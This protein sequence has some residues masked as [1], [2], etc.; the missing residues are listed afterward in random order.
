MPRINPEFAERGA[1]AEADFKRWLDYSGVPYVY[2]TQDIES[3][4]EGFRGKLKRP[5]YLVG[6]PFVGNMAFDVKSKR[7]YEDC[8]MFDVAEVEKLSAFDDLFRISTFFACL[9]PD[10]GDRAPGLSARRLVAQSAPVRRSG[11]NNAWIAAGAGPR[12]PGPVGSL[13]VRVLPEGRPRHGREGRRLGPG[14][15]ALPDLHHGPLPGGL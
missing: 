12:L 15:L 6:L 2:A 8:L 3:V 4:P 5:D 9:D 10:G 1:A 11:G 14:C 7:I 13:V